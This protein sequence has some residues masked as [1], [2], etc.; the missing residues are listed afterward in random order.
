MLIA[1]SLSNFSIFTSL[2]QKR[3]YLLRL[4]DKKLIRIFL[5]IIFW[6]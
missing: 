2:L 5:I 1:T 6:Y 4:F 3:I